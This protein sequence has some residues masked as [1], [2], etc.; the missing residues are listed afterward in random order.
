MVLAFWSV[1]VEHIHTCA[2]CMSTF[3]GSKFEMFVFQ[4][5]TFFRPDIGYVQG[6]PITWKFGYAFGMSQPLSIGAKELLGCD[7]IAL[8]SIIPSLCRQLNVKRVL[9]I[10]QL[11]TCLCSKGCNFEKLLF[12]QVGLCNLLNTPS[13]TSNRKRSKRE[14]FRVGLRYFLGV[15]PGTGTVSPGTTS[16]SLSSRGTKKSVKWCYLIWLFWRGKCKIAGSAWNLKS[17]T[18]ILWFLWSNFFVLSFC[19]FFLS[20]L[21]GSLNMLQ[22]QSLWTARDHKLQKFQQYLKRALTITEPNSRSFQTLVGFEF[23]PN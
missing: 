14:D 20:P 5:Y 22:G 9:N 17:I 13:V 18:L 21:F 4:A 1:R 8:S 15:F 16:S 23:R 11:L 10:F 6:M 12:D 7:A 2:G 19:W 3:F